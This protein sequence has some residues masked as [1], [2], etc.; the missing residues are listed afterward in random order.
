VTGASG[1]I[2]V[3]LAECFA[4]DGYDLVVSA[5]SETA[6]GEVAAR[7][8]REHGVIATPI[9]N[10]LGAVAG[11]RRLA[12]A[13][14]E[15]GLSVDVLVNN[16]G[17]GHAGALTSADLAT[18]LGMVDLNVRALVELSHLFWDGMR[19]RRRG[20]VLNVASTAAFQ[21][22]PLMA[23]YYASKAFVLS[24]SEALWE[25]ARGTGLRVSCLCPGPTVSGFRE[26][27]GT[28]KT[29]LASVATPMAS[30]PV[31]EAGYRGWQRNQRVVVTGARNRV[32][33]RLVP[34]LPRRVVLRMVR[35]L[36]SPGSPARAG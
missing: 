34:F 28:G 25:E 36:Q 12:Q 26:R 19:E 15:R 13:I 24:F 8:A 20:G 2:G 35:Q 14:A 3:D 18:E 30:R 10:D 5:R 32:L 17:Y 22:G 29:R 9:A 4:R 31:A 23:V 16:A 11:G 1:G 6:L 27:A 33:A 21:P 7:L